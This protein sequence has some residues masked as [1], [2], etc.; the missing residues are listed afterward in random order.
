[1][2]FII[3]IVIFCKLDNA[4]FYATY[5]TKLFP[6]WNVRE[7]MRLLGTCYTDYYNNNI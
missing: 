7:V 4:T 3:G 6:Q 2:L 5:Y 1:M